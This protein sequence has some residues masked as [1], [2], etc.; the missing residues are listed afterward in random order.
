MLYWYENR[1]QNQTAIQNHMS[2]QF[3]P[4]LTAKEQKMH[5]L[6]SQNLAFLYY[7]DRTV[8]IK[9]ASNYGSFLIAMFALTLIF[10][11]LQTQRTVS[12]NLSMLSEA[13]HG[14]RLFWRLWLVLIISQVV[15]LGVLIVIIW[16]YNA[17]FFQILRF[18]S[19]Y[20]GY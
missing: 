15:Y 5:T 4:G 11:M 20:S 14:Y 9:V 1:L 12:L 7:F 3:V 8:L 16:N 6:Q 18:Y 10:K 17:S 19:L 2:T 13:S